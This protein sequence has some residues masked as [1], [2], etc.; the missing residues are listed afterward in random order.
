MLS[1]AADYALRATLALARRPVGARMSLSALSREADVPPAFF[2]KVLR[3]LV[4]KGLLVG[5][6]GKT[7]G[8][9]LAADA[10]ERSLL[11]I[12]EALEGLPALNQCLT[13]TGCHR[14]GSCPAHPIWSLA[15][16]C[17]RDVLARATLGELAG[18]PVSALRLQH[19]AGDSVSTL[20]R[21]CLAF[22]G[23]RPART[24]QRLSRNRT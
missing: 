7:G 5:H 13:S 22:A 12:V 8:Y 19:A 9:E 24:D 11:D 20:P 3:T 23:E 17:M 6:R 18:A 4:Q 10:R 1:R 21:Q 15:Q 16:Q 2:Y 14:A